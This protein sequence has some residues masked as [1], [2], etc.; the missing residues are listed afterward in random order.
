MKKRILISLFTI[1]ILLAIAAPAPAHEHRPIGPYE[2]TFGW[3]VEPALVGQFNGPEI[4]IVEMPQEGEHDEE[5]EEGEHHEGT[6]VIGAEETLQLEVS[7]GDASRILALRPVFN[8]PGRYTADLIPTRPGDYTFHLTGT[9]GDTEIDE[10]FT[11]ADGMFSTIEPA[12]DVF[13][14]DEKMVSIS[15]LQAQIDELRAMIEALITIE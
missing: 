11:S 8:E 9:I 7:F 10:T 6:P 1:L 2:I 12:N 14:P 4:L 15:D 3:R 5:A 13:F